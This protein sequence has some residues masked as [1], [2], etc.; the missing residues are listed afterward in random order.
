VAD[1]PAQ[2]RPS[3]AGKKFGDYLVLGDRILLKQNEG[4]YQGEL[5]ISPGPAVKR[6]VAFEAVLVM[7]DQS[8]PCNL[9]PDRLSAK[10]KRV[11]WVSLPDSKVP[12]PFQLLDAK[13]RFR[14]T[15]VNGNTD[16]AGL[17]SS[18]LTLEIESG[19]LPRTNGG[20]ALVLR[21][22]KANWFL[23]V[24]LVL[25]VAVWGIAWMALQ[26]SKRIRPDVEEIRLK[27]AHPRSA[28]RDD[29]IQEIWTGLKTEV[30]AEI[31]DKVSAL[32]GRLSRLQHT[33]NAP[34]RQQSESASGRAEAFVE[35]VEEP[36]PDL[37]G[38][39]DELWTE[40]TELYNERLTTDWY[41]PDKQDFLQQLSSDLCRVSIV[42]LRQEG[43][44]S[45]RTGTTSVAVQESDQ[46]QMVLIEVRGAQEGILVPLPPSASQPV[47]QRQADLLNAFY[48]ESLLSNG[49]PFQIK[50]P[51]RL[52]KAPTGE[53][54]VIE[55]GSLLFGAAGA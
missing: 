48:N 6:S 28:L 39:P 36:G 11:V 12:D 52:K 40:V 29:I 1:L 43:G 45:R 8:V 44:R 54:E 3:T 22:M 27:Y 7:G 53:W 26:E 38:V 20:Q 13:L 5:I 32:E 34:H 9:N 37:T 18:D 46:G 17:A 4:R 21:W 23:L 10:D 2:T 25:A 35:P 33:L 50:R 30:L 42:T 51:A 31:N 16:V 55:K 19:G 49:G 15:A 24:L 47:S 41:N 14:L